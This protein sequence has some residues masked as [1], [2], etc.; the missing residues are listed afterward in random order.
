[1]E[2]VLSTVALAMLPWVRFEVIAG[3]VDKLAFV[4]VRVW[5]SSGVIST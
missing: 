3:D 5:P 2:M 1:M 4:G